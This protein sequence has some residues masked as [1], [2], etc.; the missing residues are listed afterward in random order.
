MRKSFVSTI[1]ILA[2]GLTFS[3]VASAADIVDAPK[4]LKLRVTTKDGNKRL[5]VKRKQVFLMKCSA[6]CS[7]RVR[8]T[9]VVPLAKSV[10]KLN[11]VK[12]KGGIYGVRYTLTR[13]TLKYLKKTY[14][15]SKLKL[16]VSAKD[17]NTGKRVVKKRSFRFYRK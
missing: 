2:A 12:P 14:R 13:P 15:R 3:G 1:L 16:R 10:S 6:A 5:E 17:L 4:P 7:A 8:V 9:L 11:F